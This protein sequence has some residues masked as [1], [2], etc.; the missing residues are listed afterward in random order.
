M[1]SG[2]TELCI[3]NVEINNIIEEVAQVHQLKI[4][5]DVELKIEHPSAPVWM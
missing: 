2:K 3:R 5:K 1:I 4:N